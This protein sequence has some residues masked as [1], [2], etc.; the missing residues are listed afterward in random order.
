MTN[1][2]KMKS[3]KTTPR[4]FKKFKTIVIDPPWKYKDKLSVKHGRVPYMVMGIEAITSLPINRLAATNCHLY[5]WTTNA[6][7]REAFAL[8]DAWGF[9]YKTMITWVKPNALGSGYYWRNNTEHC[10]FAVK[11]RRKVMRNDMWNVI[12]APRRKHSEKP[13]EF[14]GCVEEMSPKPRLE[15]FSRKKRT[16]WSV[17]GDEVKSDI[18][19]DND[20]N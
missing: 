1:L 11:G 7:I 8:L 17:W 20:S 12:I 4:Q 13:P 2:Y 19:I 14:M 5:L 3:H 15:I 6:F 9:S 18:Q 10:L 16:G